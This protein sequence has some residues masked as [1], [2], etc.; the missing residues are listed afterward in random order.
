MFRQAS[1]S[2][3][4]DVRGTKILWINDLERDW[5]NL[6]IYC[7]RTFRRFLPIL[8]LGVSLSAA[9]QYT[10]EFKRIF[11]DA[12]YLFQ[13]RFYEEA[14][15]RYKNLL[16]LDPGN[17]NILFH[18]GACCL[19]IPGNEAQA[20][21]YLKEAV[22]GV[23]ADYKEGSFKEPGAP[24]LALF[25][26]GRAYHLNNEFDRAIES[27]MKYREEGTDEDPLQLEY[28]S[29]QIEACG[30]ARLIVAEPP[31]FEFQS[32]LDQFDEDL[33]SCN[34]P[35]ISGDGNLLV[36]LV[37][38]PNDKK[39][40]MTRRTGQFWSRPRVIN[41][42]IGMV[43]ETY[44][45]SLSYD[46]KDLYLVHHFYSHSDIFV[47][48]LE[49]TRWS[50]AEALGHQI[51]G[52]TSETHASISKDGNTLYFTSDVRGGEGSFDIY[53]SRR[54][55]EGEWGPST[56]LGDVINTPYEEHTPFISS[57]DSIL[58]FSSQG[59]ASIGGI[60]VYYSELGPDGTWGEP[61]NLGYPVN[62]T[63]EDFFFN[64]GWDELDGY[65]A[66]RRDDD[67]TSNTIS[68]VIELEY[69]EELTAEIP[70]E[71]E[72]TGQTIEG[73]ETA[74]PATDS[75]AIRVEQQVVLSETQEQT[76]DQAPVEPPEQI[77]GEPQTSVQVQA[78]E[79]PSQ[80]DPGQTTPQADVQ[81]ADQTTTQ[82]EGAIDQ[83]IEPEETDEIHQVLNRVAGED[84]PAGVAEDTP[85]VAPTEPQ[86]VTGPQS[87]PESGAVSLRTSVP[88]EH[89]AYELTM[90]AMLEV[91]KV[92]DLMQTYPRTRVT[93]TG[94]ADATG[95]PAYNML[96][97]N[98]RAA[99]VAGYLEKRGIDDDR[100]TLVGMGEESPV[101][102]NSYPD[103]S[104]APLGRY[105]NRQV[106][107]EIS[108][109]QPV[110]ASL[111]GF[112][113]PES[114][115]AGS[116]EQREGRSTFWFTIQVKADTEQLDASQLE[117]LGEV[118]EY[119]CSDGIYRYTS[120]KY[121]DFTAALKALETIQ[122]SGHT[123]AFIQTLEWY[124]EAMVK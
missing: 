3:G 30:R 77:A 75:V 79:Q 21:T 123:D 53:V 56:N 112:Y 62:T 5:F 106:T 17:S 100:I 49:E 9:G 40:M 114:L 71:P 31:S 96:L 113:I 1:G 54:D 16:T 110:R 14:F 74:E 83:A 55:D 118:K 119:R 4:Q 10:K 18:C 50:E 81:A 32:V 26:L 58:F 92:A 45:V 24:V 35:V 78:T 15:S 76:G 66:V 8:L 52:R 67:P 27:Y 51:N 108:S 116:E 7:M 46:G 89:N 82:A 93:L 6:Y 121:R 39:I 98:Q 57:D 37:D 38:Y 73:E 68:M 88:F 34:N 72:I 28:A 86:A 101:A 47:S 109:P 99:Q 36:F 94:R 70:G 122:D 65:Y 22:T 85:A 95:S 102:L 25:M 90:P 80:A 48:R 104:D 107:V 42:E 103:G 12:G 60:D 23:T 64:P 97:S 115:S 20:V 43:G 59:H 69:P 117:G 91:E 84:Q 120:G 11:I 33:P 61:S 124:E 2:V 87:A 19:N 111:A 41:S 63:G 105:L 29:L 13:A 44:P